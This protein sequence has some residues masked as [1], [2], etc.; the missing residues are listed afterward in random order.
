MNFNKEIVERP[1]G[2]PVAEISCKAPKGFPTIPVIHSSSKTSFKNRNIVDNGSSAALP[3]AVKPVSV[4][5]STA[6]SVS[7]VNADVG[8]PDVASPVE[9][10][11]E[12]ANTDL[13]Q[14]MSSEEVEA[15]LASYA[16][17]ISPENLAFLRSRSQ[18]PPTSGA[19]V[20]TDTSSQGISNDTPIPP[21]AVR[22]TPVLL[23]PKPS[24]ASD[25]YKSKSN[26]FDMEGRRVFPSGSGTATAESAVATASASASSLREELYGDLFQSPAAEATP[27]R[28]PGHQLMATLMREAPANEQA[29]VA[30][31]F[32]AWDE[33]IQSE[34][35]EILMRVVDPWVTVGEV[36]DLEAEGGGRRTVR[37]SAELEL[38]NH[39]RDPHLPGF[40]FEDI[41]EVS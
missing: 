27:G 34:F 8:P 12:K 9:D 41:C 23:P 4:R 37:C 36:L 7:R 25:F 17:V 30:S 5:S 13:V 20:I 15:A 3:S 24:R 26:R 40:T 6:P 14:S 16:S 19:S 18:R 29:L 2:K 31:T 28:K 11:Y 38:Y 21:P 33:R 39:E 35:M 22:K 32:A 1:V 10:D